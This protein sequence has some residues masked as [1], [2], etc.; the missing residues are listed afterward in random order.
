MLRGHWI[1]LLGVLFLS[2]PLLAPRLSGRVFSINAFGQQ[3]K[4]WS[5]RIVDT[6]SGPVL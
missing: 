4:C 5:S 1:I 2:V 6:T 3:Y